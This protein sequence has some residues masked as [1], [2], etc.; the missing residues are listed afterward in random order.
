MKTVVLLFSLLFVCTSVVS[1]EYKDSNL[2]ML[3][4]YGPYKA[5]VYK[6][7]GRGASGDYVQVDIYDVSDDG[8]RKLIKTVDLPTPGYK[9]YVKDIKFYSVEN[10]RVAILFEIDMKGMEGVVLNDLF[11]MEASGQYKML[12][13]AESISLFEELPPSNNKIQSTR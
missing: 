11:I 9:G 5:K 10:D 8:H 12:V 13:D 1:A 6:L 4:S 2:W 7:P 3:K